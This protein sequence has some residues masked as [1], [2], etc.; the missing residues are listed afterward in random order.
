MAGYRNM[1]AGALLCLFAS[2]PDG[3][4]SEV[5]RLTLQESE[6][7]CWLETVCD[8]QY[9]LFMF[10]GRMASCATPSAS[11]ATASCD[12]RLCKDTAPSFIGGDFNLVT[13]AS[14]RCRPSNNRLVPPEAAPQI[15]SYRLFVRDKGSGLADG[16]VNG[17]VIML[18][19]GMTFYLATAF[20]KADAQIR[21]NAAPKQH[22]P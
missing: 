10:V 3:C 16:F 1:L 7:R 8:Y 18:Y 12:A 9:Y 22:R 13:W 15:E 4:D 19:P 11:C 2:I 6:F 21:G 17:S 5:A 20:S 14:R